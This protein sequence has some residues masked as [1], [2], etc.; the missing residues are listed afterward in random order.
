MAAAEDLLRFVTGGSHRALLGSDRRLAQNVNRLLKYTSGDRAFPGICSSFLTVFPWP[1]S[2]TAAVGEDDGSSSLRAAG[3]RAA[4][5]YQ[6]ELRHRGRP[7]G[8]VP[9]CDRGPRLWGEPEARPWRPRIEPMQTTQSATSQP[10]EDSNSRHSRPSPRGSGPDERRYAMAE[11]SPAKPRSAPQPQSATGLDPGFGET[12]R[13]AVVE[14]LATAVVDLL[15][16]EAEKAT[17]AVLR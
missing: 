8:D 13:R 16:A 1:C 15:L 4:D 6:R 12:R 3:L 9:V 7:R 2:G 11:A 17:P 14:S 5:E 10:F